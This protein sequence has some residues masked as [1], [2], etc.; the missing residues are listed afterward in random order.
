MAAVE[1]DLKLKNVTLKKDSESK[2][3]LSIIE[4]VNNIKESKLNIEQF[5]SIYKKMSTLAQK[6]YYAVPKTESWNASAITQ[7]LFRV[8]NQQPKGAVVSCLVSLLSDGLIKETTPGRYIRVVVE[9]PAINDNEEDI[10]ETYRVISPC[11]PISKKIMAISSGD[12]IDILK[13]LPAIALNLINSV[14]SLKADIE[15][16]KS[17]IEIASL[18]I[19]DKLKESEDSYNQLVQLRALLKGISG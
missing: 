12:P 15:Q 6:V 3:L 10:I 1:R 9:K 14:D 16:F 17:I 11:L 2:K 7:E 18:G 19:D 13:S 5:N 8:G 4:E